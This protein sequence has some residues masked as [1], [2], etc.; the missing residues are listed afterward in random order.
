MTD[1]MCKFLQDRK[2]SYTPE[3]KQIINEILLSI[4]INDIVVRGKTESR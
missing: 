1:E 4:T 3:L 2:F